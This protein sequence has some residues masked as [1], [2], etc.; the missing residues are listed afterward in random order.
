MTSILLWGDSP[1][2]TT[3]MGKVNAEILKYIGTDSEV[4]VVGIH[5]N[6]S[7]YDR[8][9]FPYNIVVANPN[10]NDLLGRQ[11]FI[12]TLLA[13]SWD[14]VITHQDLLNINSVTD[15]MLKVREQNPF[16]WIC[17]S[18]IDTD[19]LTVEDI[20]CLK[21]CDI[22]ATY[23]EFGKKVVTKLDAELGEAVR[24][25]WLGTDINKFHSVTPE[26]KLEY[27]KKIFNVTDDRIIVTNV[28]AN[29]ARKDLPRTIL[30]F[31]EFNKKVPNSAL[32]IHAPQKDFGGD[33]LQVAKRTGLS[34][35]KIF[36]NTTMNSIH[37]FAEDRMFEIYG[38][39]DL[40]IS[41]TLAEGWGLS[42]T[43]SFACRI[44]AVFPNHTSL[45]ELIGEN[46]ERGYL[47]DLDETPIFNS[48]I[49]N[50][51]YPLCNI[52]SCVNQMVHALSFKEETEL[53]VKNAYEWSSKH[54]WSIIGESWRKLVRS[55]L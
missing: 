22:P 37:G 20:R 48:T 36:F 21:L 32:Y 50:Y 3:G 43:E 52:N 34:E 19:Q 31:R 1:T 15:Y 38:C 10:S 47:I 9:Q 18:P 16:K 26:E 24:V 44:P 17:Y 14:I 51:W 49:G 54:T 12:N 42:C 27:R 40:I 33:L 29:R 46:E 2:V 30:A 41:T 6:G 28:N 35:D 5:Y 39:T 53:K 7:Y 13:G 11:T 45:T 8:K 55:L 4:T 25:M 23:S